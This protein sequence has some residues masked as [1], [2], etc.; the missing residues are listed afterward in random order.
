M[1]W[2]QQGSRFPLKIWR[3]LLRV[4]AVRKRSASWAGRGPWRP[5]VSAPGSTELVALWHHACL[6]YPHAMLPRNEDPSPH[7][8]LRLGT[9][10]LWVQ[11]NLGS[12]DAGC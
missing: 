6:L 11:A 9:Q 1:E 2:A 5:A 3:S 10:R 7:W 4:R 8:C 12:E